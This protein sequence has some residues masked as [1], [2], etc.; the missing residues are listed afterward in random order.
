M[1]KFIALTCVLALLTVS[2]CSCSNNCEHCGNSA[3]V[4]NLVGD[5]V[6]GINVCDDCIQKMTL[7]KINFTFTCDNCHETV[8]GK[9]NEIAT[10][11]G[12]KCFC[13]KCYLGG[14]S[15]SHVTE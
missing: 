7:S 13:N 1:K 10:T 2:L 11:E 3:M 12:A 14:L 4:L 8:L 5:D 6:N 15:D 9:K